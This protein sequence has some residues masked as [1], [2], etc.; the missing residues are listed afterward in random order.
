[1]RRIALWL[2]AAV[3]AAF[4]TSIGVDSASAAAA[5]VTSDLSGGC[6]PY[7]SNKIDFS[8]GWTTYVNNDGWGCGPN[9]EDCG[10][11]TLTAYGPSTW[12]VTSRQA[13]GN[14]GVL[15][16][17]DVQQ[18]IADSAGNPVQLSGL[19]KLYST[20]NEAMPH[21]ADTKVE[22]AYDIWMGYFA[23]EVMVWVDNVNQGLSA[24]TVL[25]HHVFFK[26]PY[27]LY[28][29]GGPGGE[30]I[31]SRDTNKTTG[32]VHILAMLNWLLR[33]GYVSQSHASVSDVDFGWEISSTGGVNERF[34]LSDFTLRAIPKPTF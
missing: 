31:W 14:T 27:T 32:T 6:G 16:Y 21:N 1:M 17:P 4:F 29:N 18:L 23:Q 9:G 20:F 5:C 2:I 12:S 8:N 10:P 30:L 15:T 7:Y 22:A 3:S 26:I 11:Q 19:T 13:A 24:D 28:R 33:N 25:A 34:T